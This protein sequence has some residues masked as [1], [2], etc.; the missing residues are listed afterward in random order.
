MVP[1]HSVVDEAVIGGQLHIGM[2]DVPHVL[3][4]PDEGE[5]G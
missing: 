3:T 4:K 1:P 2:A 5:T